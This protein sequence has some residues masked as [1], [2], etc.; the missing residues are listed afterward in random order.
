MRPWSVVFDEEIENSLQ[1]TFSEMLPLLDERAKRLVLGGMSRLLGPGGQAVVARAAHVSP[2][3]VNAGASEVASGRLLAPGRVRGQGGGRKSLEDKD[4]DL[5]RELLALVEP[6][7]RGDPCSPLLW[8]TKSTRK[9]AGELNALGYE[10]SHNKVAQLLN[11]NGFSLQANAKTREG[12]DDPD[13]DAQFRYIG[14]QVEDYQS[15]G[16]PVIS[17]DTKKKELVGDFKNAGAEWMPHGEP[18][19]VQVYDFPDLA[20]GKAIPYGVYDMTNNSGWVS[21]GTDH[22][23]AVFAVNSIRTWWQTMGC[24][25]YS[26]AR[27][28]LITADSGGSNGRR[29]RSWKIE[30]TKLA[31]EIGIPITVCHL[32][33]GTS[34]WNKIEHRLFSHITMNW[35]GRPL[36]SYEV[37]I[38]TIAATT[39]RAG[40][41]VK[42]K[43]DETKYPTGIS[44]DEK[45]MTTLKESGIWVPHEWHGEWNY[46]INPKSQT[47]S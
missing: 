38:N 7:K 9:L 17:V 37:I 46:T 23:T 26:N 35:R 14:D 6:D 15:T 36:T 22:D 44:I 16:E 12:G 45:T 18:R 25:T 2:T 20:S 42:A 40:L 1:V 8:T 28:L 11:A 3:T 27:R 29:V 43:L 30:L 21:V 41:T 31:T 13:R 10:V 47:P 4:P 24:F 34:K 19:D 39:T 32:P 33:P 5:L